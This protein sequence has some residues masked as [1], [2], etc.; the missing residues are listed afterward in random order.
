MNEP[1][2]TSFTSNSFTVYYEGI[3]IDLH[4]G[5]SPILS[6]NLEWK[7]GALDFSSL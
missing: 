1:Y 5:A 7:T 2:A 6:Y 3:A 4:T